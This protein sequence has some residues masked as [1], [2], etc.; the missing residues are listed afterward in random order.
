M[1]RFMP[2]PLSNRGCPPSILFST[3]ML[4][5]HDCV[6]CLEDVRH[7]RHE[8][9]LMKLLGFKNMPDGKTLGNWL[10]RIGDSTV[11]A[12]S[13]RDQQAPAI[14]GFASLQAGHAGH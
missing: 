9:G 2:A 12:G 1:D 6:K 7:L 5:K 13:S 14:N 4:M 3:F 11:D 8:S 10:R